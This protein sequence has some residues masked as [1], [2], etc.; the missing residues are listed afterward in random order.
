MSHEK[1]LTGLVG[2]PVSHVWFSDHSVVYLELG[3]LKPNPKQRGDGSQMN[4][5]GEM[6]IYCGYDWRIEDHNSIVCSRDNPDKTRKNVF[7]SLKDTEVIEVGLF[8]RIPEL[9]V[10]FSSGLWLATYG[11]SEGD[12]DWTVTRRDP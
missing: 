1:I 3:D 2:L 12:P 6:S 4:P 9:S 8:G 7:E 5:N 11:L 10:G